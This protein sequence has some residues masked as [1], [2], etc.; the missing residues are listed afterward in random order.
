MKNIP[1]KTMVSTM[2]LKRLVVFDFSL[3][4][5]STAQ[6]FPY[7]RWEHLQFLDN[8]FDL[9]RKYCI[10][11]NSISPVNGDSSYI[12]M[13]NKW[14][15]FTAR[16]NRLIIMNINFFKNYLGTNCFNGAFV[17]ILCI[18]Y[19]SISYTC[20]LAWDQWIGIKTN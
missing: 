1:R 17:V 14:T 9:F 18:F 20:F 5:S 11:K 4:T 16:T 3:E 7:F 8:K 13:L 10:N 2:I 19:S 15:Y 6:Y 12:I